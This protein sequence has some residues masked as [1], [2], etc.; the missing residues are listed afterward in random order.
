MLSSC[1]AYKINSDTIVKNVDGTQLVENKKENISIKYYGDYWFHSFTKKTTL[2]WDKTF[3]KSI[4]ANKTGKTLIYCAH[5]TI[6]P[7][8][9]T[10]GLIY[11][12]NHLTQIIK[13][14]EENFKKQRAEN[15]TTTNEL[16]GTNSFAKLSYELP[17]SEL[18][19][20]RRYIEYYS[21]QGKNTLRIIFWTT[22]TREGWL[23]SEAKGIIE[24]IKFGN[25]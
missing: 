4:D 17:D 8:C 15:L 3:I 24:T 12:D 16:I 6:E 11:N 10:L 14:V 20:K 7:Y 21:L 1:T 2:N 22:E 25:N 9:S 18:R 23:E 5:T 13:D 19:I